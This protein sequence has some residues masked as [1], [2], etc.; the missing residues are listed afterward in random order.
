M[1]AE[2][3]D[4]EWEGRMLGREAVPGG[5]AVP[6][7]DLDLDA[8]LA[9]A[10]AAPLNDAQSAQ[11]AAYLQL[12]L[13]WNARTNLTAIR[14]PQQIRRRHFLECILAAR[15]L[16]PEVRTLVDFGSGAGFPGVPIAI[17]RP[18]IAVT[19]T[20]SQHKKAAF[21][22]EVAR[23]LPLPVAVHGGRAEELPAKADCVA[24][25]AVDRMD[26]AV[27]AATR[28]VA[29]G[30]WL[31]VLTTH[32]QA[33]V[34]RAAAARG[35]ERRGKAAAARQA[36]TA[37]DPQQAGMDKSIYEIHWAAAL[38]LLSGTRERL[39]LGQLIFA[40]HSL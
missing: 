34:A 30:G 13:R 15:A 32:D 7:R 10:G 35:V 5:D 22:R 36:D 40:K 38:P 12:L 33:E 28:L 20:E 18:E 21:L 31:A 9:E 17:C 25:R 11:F 37:G 1:A 19:L 4:G 29:E 2:A 3:Q 27:A 6:G 24:L 16:P 14:D 39:L 8:L 26:E 23:S